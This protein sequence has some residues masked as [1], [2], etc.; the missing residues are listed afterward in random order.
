MKHKL[1]LKQTFIVNYDSETSTGKGC[2]CTKS[3]KE[4]SFIKVNLTII[5][6]AYTDIK[7]QKGKAKFNQLNQMSNRLS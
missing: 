1:Q 4:C 6:Q 2:K 3:D 7:A 5:S